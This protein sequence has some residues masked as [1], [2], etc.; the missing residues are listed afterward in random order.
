MFSG[1]IC[2]QQNSFNQNVIAV[3]LTNRGNYVW[4]GKWQTV[5]MDVCWHQQM[6]T[7]RSEWSSVYA[8]VRV[9]FSVARALASFVSVHLPSDC[10]VMERGII[11][12]FLGV[13]ATCTCV[14]L[15]AYEIMTHSR[16]AWIKRGKKVNTRIW[17]HHQQHICISIHTSDVP[18]SSI[19]KPSS[20]AW[21]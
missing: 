11:Y 13:T 20:T 15:I 16:A 21:W 12:G 3:Q 1:S 7:W 18:L 17:K 9:R 4:G 19:L 2:G 14:L 6:W 8:C 5:N 10:S